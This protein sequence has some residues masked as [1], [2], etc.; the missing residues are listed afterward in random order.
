VLC[1]L[2]L[3]PLASCWG[4]AVLCAADNVSLLSTRSVVCNSFLEQ[5]F[6]TFPHLLAGLLAKLLALSLAPLVRYRAPEVASA[7]YTY[8]ADVYSLGVILH[9]L[10]SG[11]VPEP[12]EDVTC[13]SMEWEGI[14]AEARRTCDPRSSLASLV[15]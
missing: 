2:A 15:R 9:F 12:E 14:S 4:C 5:C 13:D 11:Y 3:V 7:D 6:L 1:T 8:S 10:L